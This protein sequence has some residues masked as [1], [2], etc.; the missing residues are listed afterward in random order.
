MGAD[1]ILG[2]DIMTDWEFLES[3]EGLE[4]PPASARE[5]ALWELLQGEKEELCRAIAGSGALLHVSG[6]AN[7]R[8]LSDEYTEEIDWRR[9]DQLEYRLR[10][11]IDAQ[12][13]LIGGAYGR[14]SECAKE[15]EPKRLVADPAATYCLSCQQMAEPELAFHSL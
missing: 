2:V 8:D 10:E 7:E 1:L 12:D 14:C 9:R 5:G 15:I 11:I 6:V 13:R 4:E 3:V